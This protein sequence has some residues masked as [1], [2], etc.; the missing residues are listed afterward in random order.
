MLKYNINPHT[1]PA[2]FHLAISMFK[3][4]QTVINVFPSSSGLKWVDKDAVRL[5]RD[6]EW[7][8][9]TQIH[10]KGRQDGAQF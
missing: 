4:I 9:D 5:H 8:V 6:I 2:H 3:N 7:K 1:E 10:G